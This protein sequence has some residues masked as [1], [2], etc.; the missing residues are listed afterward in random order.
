MLP[1]MLFR[2]EMLVQIRQP[3]HDG[4]TLALEA[5][6]EKKAAHLLDLSACSGFD[7]GMRLLLAVAITTIAM[8]AGCMRAPARPVDPNGCGCTVQQQ[9]QNGGGAYYPYS[10]R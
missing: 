9:N 5:R 8:T 4:S 10:G 7:P 2:L 6:P 1:S 3:F